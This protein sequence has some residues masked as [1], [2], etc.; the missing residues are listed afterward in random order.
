[1]RFLADE[2]IEQPIID[3]LLSCGHD[4]LSVGDIAPGASDEKLLQ[5][6]NSEKRILLTNDKDFGELVYREGRVSSGIVLL[7]LSKESGTE[8]VAILS[9]ILPLVS[10]KL[11]Q[12]FTVLGEGIVRLRPLKATKGA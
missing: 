4:I 11:Q 3:Y 9:H 1:M 8:K 6:A 2:N 7:R 12:H 10:D 5:L